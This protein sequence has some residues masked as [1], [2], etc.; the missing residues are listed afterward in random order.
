MAAERKP[1]RRN[2]YGEVDEQVRLNIKRIRAQRH[3]TTRALAKT[4]SEA[5]R[6]MTATAISNI[7]QGERRVDV[8]DLVALADALSVAV[9]QLLDPPPGCDTCRGTPPKGFKCLACG[10]PA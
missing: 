10:T 6:P 7:E 4:M 3:I 8:G 5:G 2:T 1:R 9:T